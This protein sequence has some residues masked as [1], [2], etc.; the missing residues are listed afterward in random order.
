MVVVSSSK[1]AR[2]VRAGLDA[3][4]ITSITA[5]MD[6]AFAAMCVRRK[7]TRSA[8]LRLIIQEAIAREE[9]IG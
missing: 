1:Q 9:T 2:T 6:V 4:V 8:M 5:E 3:N 7:L